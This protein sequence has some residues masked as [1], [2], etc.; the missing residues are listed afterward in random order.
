MLSESFVPL[1]RAL[2]R[3]LKVTGWVMWSIAA[4]FVLETPIS[5]MLLVRLIGHPH[6]C[7]NEPGNRCQHSNSLPAI[8]FDAPRGASRRNPPS[9][10]SPSHFALIAILWVAYVGEKHRMLP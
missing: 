1:L 5:L 4:K 2:V 3:L 10:R 8:H 6:P 9:G 7:P